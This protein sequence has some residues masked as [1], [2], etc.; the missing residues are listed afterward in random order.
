M[1]IFRILIN[2]EPCYDQEPIQ[3]HIMD[4][5]KQIV[6]KDK[7]IER[8]KSENKQLWEQWQ[9]WRDVCDMTETLLKGIKDE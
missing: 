8:L 2:G 1:M 6:A 5:E 3:A 4:C 7:E 9:F